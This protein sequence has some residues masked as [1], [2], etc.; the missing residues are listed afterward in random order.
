MAVTTQQFRPQRE[1]R[2][3][4]PSPGQ[5]RYSE[6]W[7][8][9]AVSGGVL[10]TLAL[11]AGG[12]P[13]AAALSLIGVTGAAYALLHEPRRPRLEQVTLWLPQLPP[14]LDGLRI[15]QLSD[16]H[17]GLPYTT[18]NARWAVERLVAEQPDL[19]VMTGDF[20]SYEHAIPELPEVLAPLQSWRPRLG[21]FAVPGNH[22]YWEG[23]PAIQQTL[24]PL[25]IEFLLNHHRRLRD[26]DAEL[27]LAGVDDMWDGAHDLAATLKGVPEGVF[28]ILLSHCPDL[29]D[30][31]AARGVH[32]QLS[33][34]T[35][36]GHVCLPLL[37]SF[38]LPRHGW[39]YPI[40]Y[41]SIG[42]LQL[43]VSRGIGGLPLRFGCPPE[44][45]VLT[46]RHTSG[47]GAPA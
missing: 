29:A 20:V 43:Y 41:R 33:G 36:G 26:G 32:V 38:C 3:F 35:H 22:D 34:H 11:V 17:L 6:R 10:S 7:I 13:A 30:E 4:D 14:A 39:R 47:S 9:A 24:T 37:G 2:R 27:V 16:L 40:G 1:G 31:A 42:A 18:E 5:V 8:G 46:L 44:V 45:T 15:G 21:I 12:A 28:T 23:F 19:L 25:G